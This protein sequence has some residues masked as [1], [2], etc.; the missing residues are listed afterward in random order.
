MGDVIHN[1]NKTYYQGYS[2]ETA[3]K[4]KDPKNTRWSFTVYHASGNICDGGNS[5]TK[6]GA[7]RKARRLIRLFNSY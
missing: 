3:E 7:E 5:S 6:N 1:P 4:P 2:F